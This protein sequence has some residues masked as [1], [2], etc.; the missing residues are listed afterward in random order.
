MIVFM[1]TYIIYDN[2]PYA[3]WCWY[4]YLQH[5]VISGINGG[6]Y[7]STMEHIGNI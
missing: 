3:P 7:S 6:E 2:D 4:I 1:D 5:W